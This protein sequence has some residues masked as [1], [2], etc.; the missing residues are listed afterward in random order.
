M[1]AY[2]SWAM[3]ALVHHFIVQF[4][5]VRCNVSQG[6]W[7]TEYAIVGDDIVIGNARVA[8]AYLSVMS[9]LGVGIGLHKSLISASGTAVEFAKRTFYCGMD[10]SP[11]P[12]T[13]LQAA[14]QA[15][16]AAVEFIRKYNLS[17]TAFV[18]AAGY[19]FNV[20][21]RIQKP[22][23]KLNAK[24]RLIILA[25]NIPISP[26]QIEVFFSLGSPKSGRALFETSTL[27]NALVSTEF[28]RLK[29]ALNKI[30][31]TLGHLEGMELRARDIG[32]EWL[33]M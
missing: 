21:G 12:F 9:T 13:E 24:I 29:A 11:I 14:F 6:R 4:C 30:R 22:L 16:S 27:I 23:G 10:V 7:F 18:K 17:L 15:P 20:L 31:A 19:G 32:N 1:G 2:S 3:L 26:E 5:A 25:I 8:K 33:E 28:K